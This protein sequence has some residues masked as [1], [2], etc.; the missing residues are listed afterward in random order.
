MWRYV[1]IN[2]YTCL[3]MCTVFDMQ[4]VAQVLT[5]GFVR[6][7]AKCQSIA[8]LDSV[9]NHDSKRCMLC[10]QGSERGGGRAGGGSGGGTS[11][12]NSTE[13]DVACI[14]FGG[15]PHDSQSPFAF[16]VCS[17]AC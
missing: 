11:L 4:S 3:H 6:V 5:S 1:Y 13:A 7:V 16:C 10:R 2:A 12:S 8:Y 15:M 14:L 17:P 9:P